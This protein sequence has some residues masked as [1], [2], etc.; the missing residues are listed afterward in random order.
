MRPIADR[1]D[2]E[3][4]NGLFSPRDRT[5]SPQVF[6][7]YHAPTIV[8]TPSTVQLRDDDVHCS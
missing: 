8:M 5:D 6:F 4:L 3:A 1:I 2:T 7:E